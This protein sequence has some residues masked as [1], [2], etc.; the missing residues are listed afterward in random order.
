LGKDY[1]MKDSGKKDNFESGAA[2]DSQENKGRYDLISP[3][4]MRRLA[5]VYE[6]GASKYGDRNWEKGQPMCRVFDSAI[7]HLNQWLMGE[8]D[9][10]HLGQAMWNVVTLIH[11][12][13]MI[14]ANL[15]PKEIDDRPEWSRKG[16]IR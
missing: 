15:L 16:G 7:R 5:K 12:E 14:E 13:E 4:A 11:N 2:R 8:N 6:K 10:D 9:E 1:D 3:F